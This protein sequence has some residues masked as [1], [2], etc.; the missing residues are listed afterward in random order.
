MHRVS[1]I[2]INS[3]YRRSRVFERHYTL[4]DLCAREQFVPYERNSGRVG[5]PKL[6]I[7]HIFFRLPSKPAARLTVFAFKV[8]FRVSDHIFI[9]L[10]ILTLMHINYL[11]SYISQR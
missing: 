5:A 7:L 8:Q 11:Y 3:Y 4:V 6:C 1:V 9:Y 10:Y 2:V